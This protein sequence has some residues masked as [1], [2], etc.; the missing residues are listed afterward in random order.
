MREEQVIVIAILQ[1]FIPRQ[2]RR[3]GVQLLT[4][5]TAA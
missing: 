1:V 4:K 5:P 2:D 3:Y